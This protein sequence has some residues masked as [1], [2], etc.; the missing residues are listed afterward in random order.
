MNFNLFIDMSKVAHGLFNVFVFIVL[1]YQAWIGFKIR[2]GRKTGQSQF[3]A[4]K[5]HRKLG[6][7]LV[8]TGMLGYCFGL[9]LVSID[10]GQILEYPFHLTVGTL[11]VLFL[12]GQYGV[13]RKIKGLESSWR[14]PHLAI[15]IGIF[16]LYV[17]QIVTGMAVLF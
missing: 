6:P 16:C 17:F 10:K 9:I 1:L 15:G 11:V 3:A 4:I 14:T 8:F 7:I 2:K 12:A 5:R 13:S